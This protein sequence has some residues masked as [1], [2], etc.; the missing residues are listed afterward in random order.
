M[1]H[2]IL[3]LRARFAHLAEFAWH[4]TWP[5]S[6]HQAEAAVLLPVRSAENGLQVL[7][8]RRT[9]HLN[10]HAG[11]IS[12]PGGRREE[13][14]TS[15]IQTALRESQEEIG[16]DPACVEVLGV[17]PEF[18]TPSGFR[19]TPV[20]GL[21]LGDPAL[22]LDD[23]EVAEVFEVPLEFLLQR[24]NYQLHR[25]RWREGERR[26]HAVPHGGRFIWGATAG[27]LAMFAAFLLDDVTKAPQGRAG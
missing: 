4:E 3:A 16:L 21:L 5:L 17:L 11:Q 18:G 20:V 19:I 23:F 12:F 6:E 24:E 2:D 7:L 1:A 15:L 13:A 14:D 10:H 27:I 26:V 8:T 9:D 25:V 22:R